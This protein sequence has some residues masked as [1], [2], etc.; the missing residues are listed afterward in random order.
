MKIYLTVKCSYSLIPPA[1]IYMK[2]MISKTGKTAHLLDYCKNL[3]RDLPVSIL[4]LHC[5][6]PHTPQ[7]NL[8]LTQQW[9][10][11][12]LKSLHCPIKVLYDLLALCGI[13]CSSSPT[14]SPA[15]GPPYCSSHKWTT[16][17]P[18][19][20]CSWSFLCLRALP[21]TLVGPLLLPFNLCLA[22]IFPAS[23]ALTYSIQ[24][25]NSYTYPW[26]Q[27][28]WWCPWHCSLFSILYQLLTIFMI[29][30][31]TQNARST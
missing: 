2:K 20:L 14:F 30:L 13:S 6:Q 1:G 31:P 19:G 29:C 16:L 10:T 12:L 22:V 3:V 21:Q 27:G 8:F 18:W 24:N 23:P 28:D 11:L 15:R 25:F 4:A 26:T 7:H 17:L 9:P 5:P